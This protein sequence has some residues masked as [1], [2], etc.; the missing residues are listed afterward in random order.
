MFVYL[1]IIML[2][3]YEYVHKIG[4]FEPDLI[5]KYAFV[6]LNMCFK[7]Y[8]TSEDFRFAIAI[9]LTFKKRSYNK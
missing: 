1:G 6:P 5:I 4:Q 3:Y 9:G 2:G 8:A 7:S